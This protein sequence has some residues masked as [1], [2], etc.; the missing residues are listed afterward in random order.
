MSGLEPYRSLPMLISM[1]EDCCESIPQ[2]DD[3]KRF[4]KGDNNAI[5]DSYG[6]KI[7]RFKEH[8][9]GVAASHKDKVQVVE[10]KPVI[11]LPPPQ[12]KT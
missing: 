11:E 4:W 3:L 1:E 7:A 8:L 10:V 5:K 12:D 2:A 6:E 9:K